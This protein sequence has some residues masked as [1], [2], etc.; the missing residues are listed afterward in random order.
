MAWRT[1]DADYARDTAAVRGASSAASD[2]CDARG[3]IPA[4]E[5]VGGSLI[6]FVDACAETNLYESLGFRDIAEGPTFE[7]LGFVTR[8][9]ALG[10]G[11]VVGLACPAHTLPTA[12][13][14]EQLAKLRV[15][16]LPAAITMDNQPAWRLSS[17]QRLTQGPDHQIG[18][19]LVCHRGSRHC[20]VCTSRAT[21]PGRPNRPPRA[22]GT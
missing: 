6:Y 1:A 16:V 5:G 20:G 22:A 10:K 21:W 4:I 2:Y 15:H 14:G 13:S 7:Q 11:V 17:V 12:K 8:E 19:H 9:Q 3:R 18:F